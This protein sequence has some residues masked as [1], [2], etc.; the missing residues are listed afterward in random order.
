MRSKLHGIE[1]FHPGGPGLLARGEG[2]GE[3]GYGAVSPFV[4]IELRKDSSY[5]VP[6]GVQEHLE[7]PGI[8]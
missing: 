3:H 2:F 8:V 4:P 1:F 5:P 7:R 6:G